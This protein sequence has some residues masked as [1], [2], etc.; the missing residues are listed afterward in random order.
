MSK[1]FDD[2]VEVILSK[3][4]R[5][6][7]EEGILTIEFSKCMRSFLH[8][9][10]WVKIV[11]PPTLDNTGGVISLELWAHLKEVIKALLTEKLIAVMKSRQIGLSWL[12]AAYAVWYVLSHRGSTVML[13]SKGEKEAWELLAK[14]RRIWVQLPDFLKTPVKP[15]SSEEM[16]FPSM[17]SSIKAFAATESAGVGYTASVI[18]CDEWD[19]HPFA[20][21]NYLQ[22]KPTRDAGGQFVGVFTVDKMN[23]DT[24]AKAVWLDG[25]RKKNDFISLFFPWWVRPGRDE[26]WYETTKRNIPER[27]LAALSPALYMEQNYPASWEEA[28]SRSETVAV[29]DKKVL[30]VMGEDVRG[31]INEDFEE[32]DNDICHIYKDYHIGNFYIAASDVSLGVGGDFNV[33]CIMDVKTGDIVADILRK[34]IP[35]EELAYHSV[36]LLRHYHSPLWWPE[37][38]LYGRTVIK[39]AIELGYRRLGYR[40]DKPIS[41][42]NIGDDDLR[43]VGFFTDEKHRG[44]LFGSLIPAINDY[45]I[46]IYNQQGL[47]QFYGIIRNANNKGKI[48]A[49][50]SQHDDYV[51]AAGICWLKKS[52]VKTSSSPIK[53]IETLTWDTQHPSV[54]QRLIDKR[55]QG[56][57][58]D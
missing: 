21:Q 36:K 49:M 48:E 5:T 4:T 25:H 46:K 45:Q 33:T 28:L 43:R 10:K 2:R 29:F 41:W 58:N 13:F 27:E 22:S 54:I 26:E 14:C 37:A 20:D 6:P 34:D 52:D 35:P 7:E 24:L 40:G 55:L 56:A 39:K 16:G 19:W 18:I 31:K 8:F 3:D 50:S 17:M 12:M 57:R 53:S 44:D 32:I 47:K 51:I 1:E 9:L 23:P 15:D 38:N 11:D 42:D 30:D